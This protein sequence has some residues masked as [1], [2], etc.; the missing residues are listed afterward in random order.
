M[1]TDAYLPRLAEAPLLEAI[2]DS[3]VVLIHGPRQS[4]KTTLA[5]RIGEA[6]RYTYI[7]FDDPASLAAARSDPQGFVDGLPDRV[8]LD[9]IQR[10]D[11]LFPIIKATVDRNRTPGRFLLTG[12]TNILLL[13]TLADSLAGRVEILR[14]HPLS[15]SEITG[16]REGFLPRLLREQFGTESEPRLGREILERLA[17]GGFPAALAR[18]SE[19]RRSAWYRGYVDAIVQRDARDLRRIRSLDVLPR[20]LAVAASQ[21]ARLLNVQELS[22]PFHLS[23]V[24]IQEYV[25]LLEQLFLM[26]ELGAWH[27]SRLNRLVKTP[28]LHI[29]DTGLACAILGMDVEGLLR[30]PELR[31]QLVET[32]VYQECR[33]QAA[34]E[35]LPLRFH[36]F[37]DR[38]GTEVDI[39]VDGGASGLAGIEVKSGATVRA[40]DFRGLRKLRDNLGDRFRAG[41]VLF[42]GERALPFG[43]RL[44]AVP[45]RELWAPR[46]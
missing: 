11:E 37:R 20:L 39:M 8:I 6:R 34:G 26:E 18:S 21:T 13:P 45:I 10:V 41:V 14:L 28:K 42:D 2:R 19:R 5:R 35:N 1:T 29:G 12:S 16:S 33:R 38:D 24:T 3:P 17:A 31:G 27:S 25:T 9:E 43:D 36:H 15:Q 32:F 44:Y 7:S 40:S 4:G 22:G 23:R 46:D 30:E